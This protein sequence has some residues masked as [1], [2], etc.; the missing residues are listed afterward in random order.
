[1][2]TK[3]KA[4]VIALALITTTGASVN[5]FM[6]NADSIK[7]DNA[8]V[9]GEITQISAEASG[10]IT[11]IFVTDNQLV[12]AGDLLA[13]IDPRDYLARREQSRAAQSMAAAS[14]ENN[15]SRTEL[16][17]VKIDETA[18]YLEVAR[19]TYEFS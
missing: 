2:N 16:Q 10:R 8:Y 14:L 19:A 12:Q 7:T 5:T 9:H 13:I 6:A 18:A 11:E 15:R 3:I 4:I 17:R 1:M